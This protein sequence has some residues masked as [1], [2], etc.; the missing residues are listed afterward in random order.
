[1]LRCQVSSLFKVSSLSTH[2]NGGIK[3]KFRVARS[4]DERVK[5]RRILQLGIAVQE[6]CRM[7]SSSFVMVMQFLEIFDQVVN[8]LGIKEL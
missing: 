3:I 5:L 7:I 4:F 1:M 6:E 2:R 8:P